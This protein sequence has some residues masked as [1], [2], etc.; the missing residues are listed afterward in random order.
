MKIFHGARHGWTVRYKDEDAVAVKLADEAH[1][2][3]VDW[4]VKYVQ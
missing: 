3:M 1:K 4:F 2:D